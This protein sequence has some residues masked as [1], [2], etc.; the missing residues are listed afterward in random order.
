[1]AKPFTAVTPPGGWNERYTFSAGVRAGNLLK[2][3][4]VSNPGMLDSCT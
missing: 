4:C 1:M 2:P 3:I